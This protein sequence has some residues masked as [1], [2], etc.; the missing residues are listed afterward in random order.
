MNDYKK[1]LAEVGA[2]VPKLLL[3]EKNVDL[4]RFS[5][6]ACDQYS[7][8]PEYWDQ[9]EALVGESPS[10][11][12]MMLP[13]AWLSKSG[14]ETIAQINDTMQRYLHTQV[15]TEIGETLV[16]LHRRTSSGV[17]KGLVV[18]LDLEQYDFAPG[19]QSLIRATEG[20]IVD[21]LPPRM[22]IRRDAPLE[23]PHIMVLVDDRSNLLMGLLEQ[24][25][26]H[27]QQLYDFSLMQHGG[28]LT[29]WRVDHASLLLRIAEVLHTLRTQG[30]GFLYA[31]GDGNHSFATAKACWDEIK[32]TLSPAQQA[33]HPARFGLVELVNLYDPAL[34]FEPIHR[35]LMGVDP[36]AVQ[37]DLGFDAQCPPS[38]QVLQPLLD[39]WC[40]A[41]S[42]VEQEYIHGA[43]EC[44]ALG[45][46]PDRLAIVFPS[47]DKDALFD[48]V[49]RDGAFARKSFS[50]GEAIDKRYYLECRK[51]R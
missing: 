32:Q 30:N 27:L 50:M 11:L 35:L 14:D 1:A 38:L 22:K 16:Y 6:I 51:I 21:R 37:A 31:M 45:N 36:A 29:G 46:A 47:F 15:L 34:R 49:R 18:A 8:Q 33:E 25:L 28:H 44:R 42:G 3:P 12:R 2:Y 5:V 9:V 24:N 39:T 23:M 41:H 48:V 19:A 7:A 13:E 26:P 40:A 4:H 43:D 20:T 10:A 17:R